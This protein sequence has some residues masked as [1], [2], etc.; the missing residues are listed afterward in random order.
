MAKIEGL[1]QLRAILFKL[2]KR[3]GAAQSKAGAGNSV[4]VGYT[5]SYALPVHENLAAFHHVGQAKF[6]EDPAR[7]M[8]EEMG[9]IV[10]DAV[11]HGKTILQGLYLAGLQLQRE[12]QLLCPV[13][14]GNLKNSAFTRIE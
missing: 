9:G 12:S 3:L 1:V 4:I 10:T 8:T 2:E 14:T 13:D 6:L 7:S 11:L 5:A